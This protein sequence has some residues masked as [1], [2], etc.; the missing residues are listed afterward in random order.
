M[1]EKKLQY[2]YDDVDCSKFVR[3]ASLKTLSV[4]PNGIKLG[5]REK[6]YNTLTS[7]RKHTPPH[8]DVLQL[9]YCNLMY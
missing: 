6:K 1:K 5:R 4:K 2:S 8:I 7:C 9:A 3:T